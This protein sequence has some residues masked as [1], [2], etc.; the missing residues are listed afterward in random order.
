MFFWSFFHH[1]HQNYHHYYHNYHGNYHYHHWY[2][3]PVIR[4]KRCF[5]VRKK[6]DQV[7]RIGG[8]GGFFLANLGN[9]RKLATFF[10][11]CLPLGPDCVI[12][13][14]VIYCEVHIYNLQGHPGTWV[15]Y[16]MIAFLEVLLICL[17]S[18]L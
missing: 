18:W 17:L 10:S 13:I 2:F 14:D 9:A 15:G 5:D 1:I 3:F 8:W 7:A 4:V 12:R 6:E 11:R 16:V